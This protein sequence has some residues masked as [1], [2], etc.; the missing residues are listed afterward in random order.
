MV[1]DFLQHPG[2]IG[3]EPD[4]FVLGEEVAVDQAA[5][6]GAQGERFET[7]HLALATFDHFGFVDHQQVL[8]PYAEVALLVEP[9]FIRQ[10][11]AGLEWRPVGFVDT[12]RA[13]VH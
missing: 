12:G 3:V 7:Q 6:D 13:L 11:H 4:H 2:V 1:A 8:D 10:D 9:W 5:F